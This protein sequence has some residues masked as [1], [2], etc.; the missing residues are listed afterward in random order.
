M[1]VKDEVLN[2]ETVDDWYALSGKQGEDKEGMVNIIM[3]CRVGRFNVLM[4]HR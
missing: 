1:K 4:F 2:G 3:S